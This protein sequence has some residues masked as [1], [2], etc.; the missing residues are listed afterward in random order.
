MVFDLTGQLRHKRACHCSWRR[1]SSGVIR[2][3]PATLALPREKLK[4]HELRHLCLSAMVSKSHLKD[5]AR[6]RLEKA[7]ADPDP[8]VTPFRRAEHYWKSRLNEPELSRAFDVRNVQWDGGQGVWEGRRMSRWSLELNLGGKRVESEL[9]ALDDLP[10]EYQPSLLTSKRSRRLTLYKPPGF[11]LLPL[12]LLPAQQR[13]LVRESLRVAAKSP[14]L[15]NLD[16][17]WTLPP[18]GIWATK[19]SSDR[20]PSKLPPSSA[21]DSDNKTRRQRVDLDPVTPSNFDSIPNEAKKVPE[22]SPNAKP[23]TSEELLSK[24]RW[25]TIG[26]QYH[27]RVRQHPPARHFFC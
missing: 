6:A 27:V 11:F 10:G 22:P 1:A 26:W 20:H 16:A 9:V 12:L 15:T 24:L 7:R 21:P 13:D 4:V 3:V 25:A 14:N 2:R 18:E 17:H 5:L 23:L 19:E 8:N